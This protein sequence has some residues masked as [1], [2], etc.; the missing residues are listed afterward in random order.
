MDYD[1]YQEELMDH[2]RYPQN[3]SKITSPNFSAGEHN[4]SCGDKI[5]I[6]GVIEKDKLLLVSFHGK[7]CVISQ[8]TASIT[9][10]YCKGK[11]IDEILN[12]DKNTII[13]L[14]KVPLGP[15]RL[16]CALLSL[17]VLQQGILEFKKNNIPQLNH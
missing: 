14:V 17:Y 12:F 10:E 5:Y 2:Y 4:P 15:T 1:Q 7:G 8:A 6:E 11:T 16:K 13:E 3:T 9:T